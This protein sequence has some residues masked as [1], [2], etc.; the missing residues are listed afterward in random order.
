MAGEC[1][2]E[3]VEDADFRI[4]WMCSACGREHKATAKFE[5]SKNCPS[6][7]A[8]IVGWDGLY[9]DEESA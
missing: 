9:D 4:T 8:T 5:K 1:R 6:C 3:M 7:D 2:M